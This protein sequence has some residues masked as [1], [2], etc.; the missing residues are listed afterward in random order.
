MLTIPR[1]HAAFLLVH[2]CIATSSYGAV[3]RETCMEA[4]GVPAGDCD[5]LVALYSSTNGAS[6]S[7]TTNWGTTNAPWA[8]VNAADGRVAQISLPSHSLTGPLPAELGN[9]SRLDL[10]Y[11]S[12]N[13]LTGPLPAE[14]GN[15][16]SLGYLNLS[17][18]KL[19]G[20]LP[21]GLGNLSKLEYL[22]LAYNDLTGPLPAELGNLSSLEYFDFSNNDLAGPLPTELGNLSK[23]E[24]LNLSHNDL[25]GTLSVELGRLS[26]L[27]DLNL[28]YNHLDAD[29][30]GN[31]LIPGEIQKW[32]AGLV[33]S[34]ISNQMLSP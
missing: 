7:N 2:A 31:I 15:L 21:G 19:T 32:H 17:Y 16:S 20:P 28:G 27:E 9:L 10:L 18:T 6:W 22:N 4:L 8:G 25:M 14:L 26:N 1:K 23:L 12:G 34:D 11:L 3:D 5:A 29:A 33:N 24:Y 30:D 13:Q